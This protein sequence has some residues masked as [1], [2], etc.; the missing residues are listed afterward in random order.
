MHLQPEMSDDNMG[1]GSGV[2]SAE[3]EG[4]GVAVDLDLSDSSST[5][6]ER[7]TCVEKACMLITRHKKHHQG[8][9]EKLPS[10]GFDMYDRPQLHGGCIRALDSHESNAPARVSQGAG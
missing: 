10:I 3:L 6:G 7:G 9:E 2:L 8:I 1:G 5:S 4:L